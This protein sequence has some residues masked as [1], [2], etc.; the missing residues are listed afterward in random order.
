MKLFY[1]LYDLAFVLQDFVRGDATSGSTTTLVDNVGRFEGDDFFD[2]GTLFMLSGNLAEQTMVISS[3]DGTTKTFTFPTQ[4]SP[5]GAGDDYGAIPKDYPK[6]LMVEA[7]N[8]A[9]IDIGKL[10]N[11]N[12]TL[13]TV[14]NQEE[15]TLPADVE[16]IKRV[17]IAHSLVAPYLF[18]PHVNWREREGKLVFDTDYEPAV[19]GY[20]I[21]LSYN[22]P[23]DTVSAGSDLIDDLID[24]ELLRWSAAVFA[25][26]WRMNRNPE[27]VGARLNEALLNQNRYMSKKP[28]IFKRDPKFSRWF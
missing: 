3:W 10:P 11:T 24:R 19:D 23:H 15:Y 16:D 20:K 6:W 18:V 5:V 22:E 25:L 1:A 4:G 8:Q 28:E 2:Q 17:E 14:T 9:L 26:R 27:A 21:R 12:T 7:I 13:T